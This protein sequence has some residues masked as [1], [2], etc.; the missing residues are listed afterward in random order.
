M[1]NKLKLVILLI[2]GLGILGCGKQ[3]AAPANN[4]PAVTRPSPQAA[5]S[6]ARS[7][8]APAVTESPM[9]PE[10]NPVGDIPDSQVFIRYNSAPG[11][12]SLEVPEGWARTEQAGNVGFIDKLD[13]VK[14][15]VEA[16]ATP[17]TVDSIRNNQVAAIKRSERAVQVNSVKAVNLPGG[18]VV[19]VK[20]TSNS[21]PNS[22]TGKQVRLENSSYFYYKN[23]KLA[24]LQLWAPMGAD[25]V[26]QWKRMSESFRWDK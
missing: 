15:I 7:Q 16:S 5:T 4:P 10:K 11:G 9:K 25:N 8:Q 23:G 21:E 20:Y 26:D 1:L 18:L 12:Y 2:L 14:V 24:R 3:A 19:L 6:Q 17:P 22:V 13:G